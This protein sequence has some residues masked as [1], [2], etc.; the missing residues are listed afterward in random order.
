MRI[1]D[2]GTISLNSQKKKKVILKDLLKKPLS[3][4]NLAADLL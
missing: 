2:G 1:S 4:A 3:F